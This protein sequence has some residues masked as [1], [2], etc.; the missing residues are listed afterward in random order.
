MEELRNWRHQER[1]RDCF[2]DA[3]S[4][5]LD[6]T[7]KPL[8][9]ELKNLRN[10]TINIK[11][12]NFLLFDMAAKMIR[13][14]EHLKRFEYNGGYLCK[15]SLEL[16]QYR[17][18]IAFQLRNVKIENEAFFINIFEKCTNLVHICLSGRRMVNEHTNLKYLALYFIEEARY[19]NI[20]DF[21]K[22]EALQL[23]TEG[24]S[25]ELNYFIKLTLNSKIKELHLFFL[26]DQTDEEKNIIGKLTDEFKENNKELLACFNP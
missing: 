19:N 18:L 26:N 23:I 3:H 10:L 13:Q 12:G 7:L 15:R 8:N 14:N 17:P 2:P 4:L 11:G 16:L 6:Y 24:F 5:V 25:E 20:L 22:L 21:E 1:F 9:V